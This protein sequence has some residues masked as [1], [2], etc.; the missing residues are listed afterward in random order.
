M[1]QI[2]KISLIPLNYLQVKA[3][4]G[5]QTYRGVIDCF[6]KILQEE[7]ASAFFKGG[8]GET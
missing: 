2:C 1:D 6:R 4:R 7:G 5:Q 8:P 3:R